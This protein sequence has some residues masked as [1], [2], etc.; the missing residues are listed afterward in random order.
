LKI[1]SDYLQKSG[2]DLNSSCNLV[3][4]LISHLNKYRNNINKFNILIKEVNLTAKN[5]NIKNLETQKLVRTKKL[6]TNLAY[7]LTETLFESRKIQNN[8]DIKL[9]I[10]YLVIDRMMNEL[11]RRFSINSSILKGLS[12]LNPRNSK[13]FM[14]DNILPFAI[15]YD[16]D[17]DSLEAELKLLPN[18][19]KRQKEENNFEVKTIL[20]FAKLLDNYKI[21]FSDTFVLCTIA[22]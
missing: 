17:T 2:I 10:F 15:H 5:N 9:I 13:F 14:L 1:V 20:D 8:N 11:N 18:L 3:N 6:P 16:I 19:I 7:Y 12:S 4:T 22:I 21:A